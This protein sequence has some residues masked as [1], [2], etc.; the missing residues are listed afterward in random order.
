MTT[1]FASFVAA[2]V[3]AAALA[4][5]LGAAPRLQTPGAP[6]AAIDLS[7]AF[8]GRIDAGGRARRGPPVAAA[9]AAPR[10]QTVEQTRRGARLRAR[11]A[12]DAL[13]AAGPEAA[14]PRTAALTRRGLRPRPEGD[15][16]AFD[17]AMAAP[18][19]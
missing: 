15:A 14:E 2:A 18:A 19:R 11:D 12:A 5:A 9:P 10:N 1:T 13:A 6:F 7:A 3:G 16:A 17:A 8:E 4:V